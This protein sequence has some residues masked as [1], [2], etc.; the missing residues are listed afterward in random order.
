MYYTIMYIMLDKIHI[1][2]KWSR[3]Y[4]NS[5]CQITDFVYFGKSVKIIV[6]GVDH[7]LFEQVFFPR[8]FWHYII[9]K[10]IDLH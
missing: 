6:E 5:I 7:F 9:L 1:E 10:S 8:G 2:E 3:I 4:C